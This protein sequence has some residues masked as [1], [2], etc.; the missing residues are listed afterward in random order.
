MTFHTPNEPPGNAG[1]DLCVVLWLIGPAVAEFVVRRQA[2]N[3]SFEDSTTM[4]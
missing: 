2:L 3:P 1:F 4:G